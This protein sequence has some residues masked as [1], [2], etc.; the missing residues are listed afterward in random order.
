M[1]EE[2][3]ETNV[4]RLIAA[5]IYFSLSMNAAREMFGK[6]Y[7]SLG[8]VE[9]AAVDQAVLQAVGANY[10]AMTPEWL[11]TPQAQPVGFQSPKP[12]RK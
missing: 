8:A 2:K 5:E 9:K 1:A 10:L 4:L 11:A 6:S 3:F 7:F 12:E